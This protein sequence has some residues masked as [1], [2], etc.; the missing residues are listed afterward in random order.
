MPNCR[1]R[2]A[3]LCGEGSCEALRY[4]IPVSW[5][6]APDVCATTPCR[7][8][9]TTTSQLDSGCLRIPPPTALHQC[10]FGRFWNGDRTRNRLIRSQLLYPIELSM[11]WRSG[12]RTR[13]AP[14][15]RSPWSRESQRRHTSGRRAKARSKRTSWDKNP[16]PWAALFIC[17]H[18]LI[19]RGV[20]VR[21]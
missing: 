11:W 17:R 7:I 18:P 8:R 19:A 13:R 20:P 21:A 16:D 5:N 3:T 6:Q 4:L 1:V 2:R 12:N 14:N 10:P 15:V 9:G